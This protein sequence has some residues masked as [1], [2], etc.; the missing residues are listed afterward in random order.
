MLDKKTRRELEVLQAGGRILSDILRRLVAMV[1]PGVSGRE[2]DKQAEQWIRQ[3]GGQASFFNYHGYPASL[4][5]SVNQTVVHGLPTDKPLQSGDIVGLDIGMIYQGLYTDMAVTV[6]VGSISPEAAKLIDVTR[7]ALAIGIAQVA[8]GKPIGDI[9]RAIEKFIK[10]HG[11]GIVRDLAGH[12][13][14][15][16]VHEDPLVLNF[17]DGEPTPKMFPGLVIAIE[18]MII[19]GGDYRVDTD[20]NGWD[21]RSADGS[22]AAHFE[23]SVAVTKDGHIILTK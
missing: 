8:P 23:H 10:P 22:L 11:Y 1:R 9:G 4:C 21:V 16:Q 3:A 20:A 5:V 19:M 17:N 18:P 14:G 15:R 6:P 7:Q 2:L 12:G 13:V